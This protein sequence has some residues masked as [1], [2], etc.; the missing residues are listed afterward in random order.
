MGNYGFFRSKSWQLIVHWAIRQPMKEQILWQNP[1]ISAIT[2]VDL[3]ATTSVAQTLTCNIGDITTAVD[4][5]GKVK[6]GGDITDTQEGYTITKGSVNQNNVQESTLTISPAQLQKLDTSS[7]VTY[8]CSA[9]SSQYP[10]SKESPYQSLVVTFHDFGEFN[11][12][13]SNKSK[14]WN[15][16][17]LQKTQNKYNVGNFSMVSTFQH[18][19]QSTAKHSKVRRLK[20]PVLQLVWRRN[21][22]QW[23]GKSR[24]REVE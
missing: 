8:K 20:Y 22:T 1:K 11:P 17:T 3:D 6:D 13:F 2:P 9:K 23:N 14:L 7:P 21:W 4:V 18:W 15:S 16:A 10:Q 12:S 19:A 24:N 5:K